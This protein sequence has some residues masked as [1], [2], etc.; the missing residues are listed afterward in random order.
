MLDESKY[1]ARVDEPKGSITRPLF[2]F[3]C[4]VGEEFSCLIVEFDAV[5]NDHREPVAWEFPGSFCSH[6]RRDTKT[7]VLPAPVGRDPNLRGTLL[8]R[9]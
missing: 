3:Y 8:E 7:T 9:V 5:D 1:Y 4:L 6:S 2:D